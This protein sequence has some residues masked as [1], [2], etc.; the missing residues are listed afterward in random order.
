MERTLA[1]RTNAMA[2]VDPEGERYDYDVRVRLRF[3]RLGRGDYVYH[4]ISPFD[5]PGC[6][7]LIT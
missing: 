7:E 5:E 4:S 6:S 1:A 2:L 3:D